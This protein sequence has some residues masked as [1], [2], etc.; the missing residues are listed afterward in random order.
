MPCF[1]M[2]GYFWYKFGIVVYFPLDTIPKS[3]EQVRDVGSYLRELLL[4][5]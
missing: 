3:G 1:D 4:S 2:A 5:I